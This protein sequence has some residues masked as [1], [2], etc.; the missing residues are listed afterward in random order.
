MERVANK[1]LINKSKYTR[2]LRKK[3]FEKAKE[4]QLQKKSPVGRDMDR[5]IVN[6][7]FNI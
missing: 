1:T 4:N 2:I 7:E 5:L 3:F 6:K